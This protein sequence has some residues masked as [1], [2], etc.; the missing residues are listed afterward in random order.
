MT[1][2]RLPDW[3]DAYLRYT[4]NSEPDLLFR[5]WAAISTIA[6]V[7][8]RK[9]YISWGPSLLFYPNMYIVLVGP[10]G[11]RKGTA[12]SPSLDL[13]TDLGNISMAANAT[14]LQALIS[15]LTNTSYT[16]FDPSTGEHQYHASLTI[17][18]KEFTVFLGYQNH[19]LMAALCD[20]Y[21]CD[22]RW[23]YETIKRQTEEI[24]GVWVNLFGGTTPELIA[25][26]L[27]QGAIGG[28]LTSR[29][30][31]I[32]ARD[33]GKTVPIPISSP[34]EN[35]L[36]T[37][38]LHD[39]EKIHLL[40][41]QFSV[42]EDFLAKWTEWY[43]GLDAQ[44]PP[45]E[46]SKMQGYVK[47]RPTHIMKLSMIMSA[48]RA[49]GPS[50]CITSDDLKRATETLIEAESRMMHV[51]A[52]FGKSS[53]AEILPRVIGFLSLYKAKD[54]PISHIA[55]QFYNDLDNFQLDRVLKTLES[56]KVIEP[57]HKPAGEKCV[58]FMG[59]PED[60]DNCV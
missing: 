21:D 1:D 20:W 41:G 53:V 51:F 31:F 10:S 18:S 45:F 49:T 14:S 30:I 25:E 27:P 36:R 57:I 54:I 2:R 16:D 46:D 60:L 3:I 40:S 39:L 5:K 26:S 43:T 52:G 44:P 12:M 47:R 37:H 59:T 32:Y 33:K 6:S 17:F 7:L 4:N 50:M 48:S 24:I 23:K 19:E 56:M 15:R 42:T 11:A 55:R 28:G 58:K 9:C 22:R 13:I 35:E 34:G 29:I 8:Q 38:L